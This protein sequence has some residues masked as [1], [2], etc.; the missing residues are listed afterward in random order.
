MNKIK[1]VIDKLYYER[2]KIIIISILMV[3]LI[4]V[5]LFY[6]SEDAKEIESKDVI[7]EKGEKIE[8]V[9]EVKEKKVMVDIKGEVN[10]PGCYEVSEDLRVKDVIDLAG[11]LT[12]DA[13][14]TSINLSSKIKDEMVIVIDKKGEANEKIE[15]DV[16]V[17]SKTTSKQT[18]TATKQ[19]GK[20]SINK[21]TVKEL[22]TLT[23]IGEAKAKK[24]IEYRE[25]NGPFSKIEDIK[26]VSGIGESIF[27]KIKDNIT[28]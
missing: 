23:G 22:T 16:S 20:I 21:G 15:S 17:N 28:L 12:K 4:S 25:K 11:G 7:I 3:L 9:K 18:V 5:F 14:T 13:D 10:S 19:N 8:P 26:K 27:A 24:I 1:D 2:K 6:K